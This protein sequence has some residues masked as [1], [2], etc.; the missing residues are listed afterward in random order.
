MDG[1]PGVVA[2][3]Q[4]DA[5]NRVGREVGRDEAVGWCCVCGGQDVLGVSCRQ[6]G[7]LEVV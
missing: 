1:V 7:K 2:R 5:V 3:P 6:P 4:E